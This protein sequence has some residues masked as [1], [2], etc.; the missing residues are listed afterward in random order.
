[1]SP[2]L[3]PF[4]SPRSDQEIRQFPPETA[5]ASTASADRALR[6]LFLTLFLR[7]RSSRGLRK[8]QTPK[9]VGSKL[10]WALFFYAV[11]GGFVAI[12]FRGQPVFMLSLYL[13]A[14][15]LVF[16][17]M[18]VASSA[19][20]VLFN[21]EEGDILLHRPVT[22]RALLQAKVGVLVHVSLW[23][24][25]AF[26]LVALF[27]GAAAPGSGWMFPVAHILSTVL[28]GLFC[29]GSV[30][31]TYELCLRWLGRERLDGLMTTVQVF[32]ALAAVLG[33]QLV[34]RMVIQSGSKF[35]LGPPSWWF[36]LLPPTWFASLDDALA[37]TGARNSWLL[38]AVGL[39][40]VVVVLWMAFG[41]LAH[42]FEAGLQMLGETAS[43]SGK[44]A[45]GGRR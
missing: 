34:P 1:M 41:K 45:G 30:V 16:L 21:K 11:F 13:H 18:F 43:P 35:S 4:G 37:G 14:M 25:G 22:P 28:E 8:E 3:T 9:T 40:A 19:G 42:H 26:N 20:E 2:S 27:V 23:L 6:R 31:L 10:G 12:S 15:T 39:V 17:G 36:G 44:G 5:P 33:G 32:V 7:G 29:T 24:A 38:A